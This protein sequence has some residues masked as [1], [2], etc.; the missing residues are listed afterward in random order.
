MTTKFTVVI[1]TRERADT[2][3]HAIKTCVAQDYDNLEILVSDCFSGDNT[4]D[5]IYSF[6]DPRLKY[7]NPGRTLSMSRHWEFALSHVH[8][9]YL[10]CLG[11]DDG[12]LPHAVADICSVLN[13]SGSQVLSWL[14]VEYCWPDHAIPEYQNV[15]MIPLRNMLMRYDSKI[16]LR[17]VTRMWLPYNRT[18]CIYNSVID[19]A[20]IKK[21]R[22]ASGTFFKCITPDV[23]SGVAL[24]SAVNAYLYSSRPFS[25]NGASRHSTG[26][27]AM[28]NM[29]D[30]GPVNKFMSEL[31]PA[32]DDSSWIVAGSLTSVLTDAFRKANINCFDGKIKMNEKRIVRR[33]LREICQQDQQQYARSY[34]QLE[35]MAQ[36]TNL[37]SYV[38]KV[39]ARFEARPKRKNQISQGLDGREVLTLNSSSFGVANVYDATLLAGKILNSYVMP[40]T[41]RDYHWYDK[42]ISRTLRYLGTLAV[43]RSL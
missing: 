33:I 1:P 37:V 6:D 18:P 11:D 25:V 42:A 8:D 14:K 3:F 16:A 23:Y 32:L 9:G 12:L 10:T 21:I 20:L 30:R 5:V 22:S 24:L 19:Y 4:K 35:N 40:D 36:K 29:A 41:I 27:S 15:L 31:D 34:S 26:T 38:R 7:V 17:D 13:Q 43:D 2:L 39:K 28:V